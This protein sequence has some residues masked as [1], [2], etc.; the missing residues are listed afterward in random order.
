VS[1][2]AVHLPFIFKKVAAY[3]FASP[4]SLSGLASNGGVYYF[5]GKS[6]LSIRKFISPLNQFCQDFYFQFDL[7]LF[8]HSAL[9]AESRIFYFWIPAFT[10]MTKSRHERKIVKERQTSSL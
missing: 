6:L 7:Y 2:F 8:G 3:L 1:S 4:P 10:G 5:P 9:D